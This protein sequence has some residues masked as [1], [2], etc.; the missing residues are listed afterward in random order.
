MS[1]PTS[2]APVT[3][4]DVLALLQK[5]RR[6]GPGKGSGCCPA[7]DDGRPSLD[8]ATGKDGRVLLRCHA[9]CEFLD[10]VAALQLD[11]R[12]FFPRD[13]QPW[14]PPRRPAPRADPDA[15]VRDLFE[16]LCRLREP[17]PPERFRD[18][19]RLVGHL[20]FRGTRGYAELPPGF[21]AAVSV[22]TFPLRLLVQA[23]TS[24]V[25]QGTPRRWFS[26]QALARECE[27]AAG[28]KGAYRSEVF[29]FARL[30]LS[31]ARRDEG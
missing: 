15:D 27:H 7:H 5:A 22:E 20:L 6:T 28:T 30:A 24:L 23:M 18:E 1:T 25:E 14:S 3:A 2:V 16:R 29:F 19:L 9:G 4:E 31:V 21:R 11:P 8:V 12:Q 13:D 17:P 10:I 26:A